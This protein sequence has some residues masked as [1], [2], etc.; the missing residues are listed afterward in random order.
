MALLTLQTNYQSG[1]KDD[2]QTMQDMEAFCFAN[3]YDCCERCVECEDDVGNFMDISPWRMC[4]DTEIFK[5]CEGTCPDTCASKRS[6]KVDLLGKRAMQCG[7][8]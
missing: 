2:R 7:F 5:A 6:A 8:R 4:K 1:A 3:G